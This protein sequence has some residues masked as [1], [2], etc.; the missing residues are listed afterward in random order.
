ME[1]AITG[2]PAVEAPKS[3][4]DRL[5]VTYHYLHLFAPQKA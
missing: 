4:F 2:E 1:V 5:Q 3:V